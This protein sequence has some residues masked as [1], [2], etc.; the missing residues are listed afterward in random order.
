ML[1]RDKADELYKIAIKRFQKE[2]PNVNLSNHIMESIWYS[3]YGVLKSEGEDAAKKYVE[4][5][6]LIDL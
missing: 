4:S 5:A 6:K 3:I 1:K 2:K